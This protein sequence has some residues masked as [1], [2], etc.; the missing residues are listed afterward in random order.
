MYVQWV[1][2]TE[3]MVLGWLRLKGWTEAVKL[4]AAQKAGIQISFFSPSSSS[5]SPKCISQVLLTLSAF[6][7]RVT[8]TAHCLGT[9]AIEGPESLRKPASFPHRH[10]RGR[11]LT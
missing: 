2:R 9:F 10:P 3:F 8:F 6:K 7:V 4:W 1:Q 11:H 5:Q